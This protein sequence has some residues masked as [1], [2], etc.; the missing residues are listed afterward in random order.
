MKSVL[1]PLHDLG[2]LAVGCAG[3]YFWHRH[4][5][6]LDHANYIAGVDRTWKEFKEELETLSATDRQT[7]NDAVKNLINL[8]DKADKEGK[9]FEDVRA[10]EDAVTKA[11][12][13]ID[14]Y[15]GKNSDEHLHANRNSHAF[16]AAV[17]SSV[18]T[19]FG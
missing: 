3:A 14:R 15:Y 9:K 17:K 2:L 6:H 5:V 7:L 16:L 13:A 10:L 8:G 11:L 4:T 1:S 12:K 18:T 19:Q